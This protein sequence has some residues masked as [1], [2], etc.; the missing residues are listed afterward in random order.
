MEDRRNRAQAH[1]IMNEKVISITTYSGA[2]GKVFDYKAKS[3]LFNVLVPHAV[4]GSAL[5]EAL[6]ASR[7][8]LSREEDPELDND[9]IHYQSWLHE[10]VNESGYKTKAAFLMN[11]MSCIIEKSN[12]V[13]KLT[14]FTHIK[15]DHWKNLNNDSF[16]ISDASSDLELGLALR[17]CLSLCTG[18]GAAITLREVRRVK[19]TDIHG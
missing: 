17:K 2:Y 1:V 18:K 3:Y 14:P 15:A 19:C 8:V 12:G 7:I 11:M 4:L 13:I 10:A 9:H 16:E 6:S 5:N